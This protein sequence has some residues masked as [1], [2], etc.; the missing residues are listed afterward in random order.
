MLAWSSLYSQAAR[1]LVEFFLVQTHVIAE[2]ISECS[3]ASSFARSTI[4]GT[5]KP[6]QVHK[7]D[8]A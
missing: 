7:D 2:L 3:R 1:E 4:L 8:P 6:V 5:V